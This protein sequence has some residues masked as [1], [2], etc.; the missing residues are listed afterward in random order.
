MD[1]IAF[2]GGDKHSLK[3]S[4]SRPLLGGKLTANY[5]FQSFA[6]HFNADFISLES[7]TEVLT[8][9]ETRHEVGI[10]Y[11]RPVSKSLTLDTILLLRKKNSKVT[12]LY[13]DISGPARFN[14]Q[15]EAK[16]APLGRN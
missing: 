9:P 15:D 12:D 13:T 6:Y 10:Q 16:S 8:N 5:D 14:A 4:Q 3:L 7:A 11:S 1:I 2:G